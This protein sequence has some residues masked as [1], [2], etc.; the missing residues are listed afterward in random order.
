MNRHRI[1]GDK[2]DP[3]GFEVFVHPAQG[4]LKASILNIPGYQGHID[5]YN[6]KYVTLGNDLAQRGFEFI[7][8]PNIKRPAGVAYTQGLLGD[9][10]AVIEFF[11]RDVGGRHEPIYLM[12]FSAGGYAAAVI[13]AENPDVTKVLLMEPSLSPTLLEPLDEKPLRRFDGE[14]YVVIGDHDGVGL[15]VGRRYCDAFSGASRRELVVIP[16]CDHQFTG[17]TNGQIMAKAPLWA[18]DGDD[19]FP[20]PDGGLILY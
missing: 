15:P 2:D 1:A 8:M 11:S 19:T 5:G 20:S 17:R 6:R 14:A 18:F 3:A 4:A 16:D 12:G 10:R 13:A 9:V 7:R